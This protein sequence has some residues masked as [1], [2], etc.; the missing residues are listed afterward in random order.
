[1]TTRRKLLAA[2]A[3]SAVSAPLRSVAQAQKVHRVGVLTA[4]LKSSQLAEIFVR[5]LHR[6]G[7]KENENLSI[8][9]RIADG[10]IDRST[11]VRY[12]TGRARS[13]CHFCR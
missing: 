7:Y 4:T 5:E 13:R 3:A 12:G 1:M 6:L 10:D 9:R 2:V 11:Y 8:V